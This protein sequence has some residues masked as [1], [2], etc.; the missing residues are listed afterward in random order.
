MP[1]EKTYRQ[2]IEDAPAVTEDAL[3]SARQRES[4]AAAVA[5]EVA[6]DVS[7]GRDVVVAGDFNTPF[8]E[9]CKTGTDLTAGHEP[10]HPL[11]GHDHRPVLIAGR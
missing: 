4:T 1:R 8:C 6:K 3:R 9:P 11:L 2:E 7:A 5:V 10:S